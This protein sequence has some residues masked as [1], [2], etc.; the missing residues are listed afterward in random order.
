MASA[1]I[2]HSH[3]DT[4]TSTSSEIP[5]THHTHQFDL[6]RV[7]DAF[8]NCIQPDNRLFLNEYIRA[9]EELC[10]FVCSL[11][12]VFEWAIK[13]LNNK[14]I[15][16][17]E[18][19]HIDPI[20]YE[21]I[22][23]MIDYEVKIERIKTRETT[24][25]TKSGKTLPNGCRTLLRLH[26]ALAFISSFLSEMRTASDDAS[27]ASIAWNAYSSTLGNFHSWPV[28]QTIHAA[29]RLTVPNRHI[30]INKLLNKR[31]YEEI[32][33]LAFEIVQS[34]NKIESI[35]QELYEKYHLTRLP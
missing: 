35:T 24:I 18:Y 9:Y 29:I 7:R 22:Q 28:R 25:H 33:S 2:T 1:P 8:V 32:D 13:D 34:C 14:L 3:I 17:K 19:Q 31:S 30:L 5:T 23:S 20:N 10:I 27:S 12:P 21:S 16:L 4:N 26:R 11:G 6:K 15:I